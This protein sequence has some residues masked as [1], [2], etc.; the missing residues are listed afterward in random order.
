MTQITLPHKKVADVIQLAGY[1][2]KHS[3]Y[4]DCKKPLHRQ[5]TAAIRNI[6]TGI[7]LPCFISA[8]YIRPLQCNAM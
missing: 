8:G 2:A 7:D 3:R 4:L 1:T 6:L 5:N